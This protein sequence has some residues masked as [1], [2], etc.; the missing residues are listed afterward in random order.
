MKRRFQI[1]IT[2]VTILATSY[3]KSVVKSIGVMTQDGVLRWID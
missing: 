1:F 2:H 3:Y